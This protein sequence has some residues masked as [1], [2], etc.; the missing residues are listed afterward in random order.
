MDRYTFVFTTSDVSRSED[1]GG[2]PDPSEVVS[3]QLTVS[4]DPMGPWTDPLNRFAT[5]LSNIYGYN[6]NDKLAVKRNDDYVSL[7][8]AYEYD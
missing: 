2:I 8:E 4:V 7:K 1:I 5:F 3:Q 6:I